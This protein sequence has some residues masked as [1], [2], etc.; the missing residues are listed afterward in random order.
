MIGGGIITRV[1]LIKDIFPVL[2]WGQN[3]SA[4]SLRADAVAGVVVLFITIPQV[5]AYAFLAG[6]PAEAGLYACLMSLM[7]YAL[8]GSSKAL[9]VGPT[10][11]VAMMTLEAASVYAQPG[12]VTYGEVVVQLSVVTGLIL[13]ALRVI[14]FGSVVSFLSHAVITGFIAAAALLIIS[15][16]FP[17]MIGL[18]SSADTSLAG[19]Y[20]YLFHEYGGYEVVV[21]AISLGAT[22]LLVFCRTWLG[23]V[24]AAMR[25]PESLAQN[26]TKSAPMYAVILGLLVMAV[27]PREITASVSVVGD[28]P[29][30]LPHVSVVLM[31]AERFLE[32][33]PSAFLI[34]MVIFMES[35]SIGMAI[36][37]K[38]R[39]KINPNQELVGLGAAN[40]GSSLVGG[41]PVAGSFARTI[42]NFSS[43]AVSQVA[44]LVTALLV[45]VTLLMF[46]TAFHDLPKGVLSAIIVVSAWQLIDIPAIRKIFQFNRTDAVT[47]SVTFIAVLAFGVETGVLTGIAISFLLLIRKSS[48]PHIAVVGR[49]GDSEHFRNVNRF[50][51]TTSPKVLAVRVDESFYF[52]NTRHIENFILAQIADLEE[53]EHVLLICTAA[54]F[55]DTSGLEMLEEMSENLQEVDVTL[56]LAEVKSPVMDKLRETGFYKN[57]AGQVFFTTD[58][59]MKELAGI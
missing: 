26:L 23:A 8:F 12:L 3:Y 17:L 4:A 47:F 51:V 37:S 22:F 33:L 29:G 18:A 5:I 9:A 27:L 43:G 24:L 19:V 49:V 32:L 39:D 56:H 30:E 52:V 48:K 42:V 10:A 31:N 36:A 50:D 15:N 45:L 2:E 21:I 35:T 20:R 6:M 41:F 54:N 25:V 14:N 44:S 16:Q 57:M 58:L 40:L 28:V 11:I 59:A 34:A 38:S 55:I 13:I 1:L 46:S 7:G 53:I